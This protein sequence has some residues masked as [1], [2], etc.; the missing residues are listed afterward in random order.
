MLS[1]KKNI[2]GGTFSS[3]I[4]DE[5]NPKIAIKNC[6]PDVFESALKEVSILNYLQHPNIIKPLSINFSNNGGCKIFMERYEGSLHGPSWLECAARIKKS[7]S[8]LL[9]RMLCEITS[10]IDYMHKC[11]I[12]HADLKPQ[13]ILYKTYEY[14]TANEEISLTIR[15]VICDFNTSVLEIHPEIY[16][17]I[18]SLNYRAPE[19]NEKYSQC[20]DVKRCY[21]S[22]KIDVWS[23]GC[24]AYELFTGC[25]FMKPI[26]NTVPSWLVAAKA[27]AVSID[28]LMENP[29]SN[30]NFADHIKSNL[31][32]MEYTD[33]TK[34]VRS[35]I[36]N[37]TWKDLMKL[38]GKY[39]RKNDEIASPMLEVYVEIISKCLMPNPHM[40]IS[41]SDLF[42]YM[43]DLCADIELSMS[44]D[45]IPQSA[46]HPR[47]RVGFFENVIDKELEKI[48]VQIG[49]S[50]HKRLDEFMK[51]F[52]SVQLLS[53]VIE[54]KY[55]EK[56]KTKKLMNKSG[57]Q[58]TIATCILAAILLEIND[59]NS[60]LRAHTTNDCII[61]VVV[62]LCG[63]LL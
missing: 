52:K 39:T 47:F 22:D 35:R 14:I 51:H 31:F 36:M 59:V 25:L 57:F 45:V 42:D 54:L 11:G 5:Y 48:T 7:P 58:I 41:S 12:I 17:H 6:E 46:N 26:S 1:A 18:Q 28:I 13:N 3:V 60:E 37:T 20:D 21:I 33:V 19:V 49:Q 15:P 10:A 55:Y 43:R 24:I 44:S 50:D 40:R 8:T 34:S 56:K 9:L 27:H 53:K 32:A 38:S 2:G 30:G 63:D 16:T 61:E 62:T 4:Y 29:A 23:I